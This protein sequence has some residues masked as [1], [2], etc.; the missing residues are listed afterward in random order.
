MFQ[1]KQKYF[2]NELTKFNSYEEQL[3]CH[4]TEN[5]AQKVSEDPNEDVVN[6]CTTACAITAK[7]AEDL[8]LLQNADTKMPYVKTDDIP[9]VNDFFSGHLLAVQNENQL[10]NK[11]IGVRKSTRNKKQIVDAAD[12]V[13]DSEK[14][15][16]KRSKQQKIAS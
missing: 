7:V 3:K 2:K 8:L 12:V 9:N 4:D 1:D 5:V 6:D 14:L 10:D 11:S 16:L 13:V 15:V